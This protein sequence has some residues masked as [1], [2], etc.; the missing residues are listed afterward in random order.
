LRYRKKVIEHNLAIAFPEWTTEQLK[1][2]RQGF[3]RHFSDLI[4][5][6]LWS[7]RAS[8]E[9]IVSS[10]VLEQHPIFEQCRLEG[11]PVMIAAA[12]YNNYELGALSAGMQM[13][14][15]LA[16]IYARLVDKFY[17][18]KLLEG[19]SRLGMMLW[20]RGEVAAKFAEWGK[21]QESFAVAFAFDQSPHGA[22]RK[23]W[24][25]FLGRLTAFELG[26]E[27]YAKRYK[28]AVVYISTRR[29]DRGKYRMTVETISNNAA[30]DAGL[31][32]LSSC[33]ALL[34]RDLHADPVGWMWSH[35]RWKLD[36]DKDRLDNDRIAPGVLEQIGD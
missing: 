11:R 5:E 28:A 6:Q 19:R 22:R 34:E 24:L 8:P 21:R 7:L 15:P 16:G 26:I 23:Y 27:A 31:D 1:A 4:V 10:C 18:E 35:R 3:Y 36:F 32:V 17:D 13:P 33:A 9:E 12:H 25:P 20:P 14:I 2:V 29:L 30:E